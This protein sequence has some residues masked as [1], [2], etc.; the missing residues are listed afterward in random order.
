MVELYTWRKYRR[1]D[2]K[3][4]GIDWEELQR[5][6]ELISRLQVIIP[7][8]YRE[9]IEERLPTISEDT[10]NPQGWIGTYPVGKKLLRVLPDP[11]LIPKDQFEEMMSELAGWLEYLGPFLE[12]FLRFCSLEPIFK[13]LLCE[14]Y[15]RRLT[16]YTEIALSHFIPRDVLTSEH[17]SPELRGRPLWEKTLSLRAKATYLLA[18]GKVEFS[19][20]TL[21]NLLLVR[22]HAELFREMKEMMIRLTS[23]VGL[24]EIMK[25]WKVYMQYH[26]AFINN[27]LWRELFE[28]SLETVFESAEILEK[29]RRTAKGV[30]REII[31]LWEAYRFRRAFLSGYKD[32]F[33]NAPKPLSK[34]Y[35]LWCLKKLCDIFE[36]DRKEITSFPCRVKFKYVGKTL[37]LYYTMERGIKKYSGILCKIPG[38]SLGIPDFVIEDGQEK[39]IVCIMDAKCKSKLSTEDAQRFLSYIFDYMYPHNDQLIGLIF[40]VPKNTV[41]IKTIKVKETEIHLIPMTPSTYMH[42]KDKIKSIIK[43]NLI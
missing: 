34:I 42:V 14:S 12:D 36:I 18:Y 9:T 25:D 22:F 29:T 23:E 13:F 15:S 21:Q 24:P 35:E 32:R 16:E 31:D 10:F 7:D 17:I 41:K 33:D 40:F 26:E 5:L 4:A 27:H 3:L 37:T 38:A 43:T 28:E 20:R 2:E 6:V 8:E 19:F 1:D 39:K 30:W 11:K